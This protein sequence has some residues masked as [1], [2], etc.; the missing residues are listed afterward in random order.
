MLKRGSLRAEKVEYPDGVGCC[1][2]KIL[3]DEEDCGM[4][5]D[6]AEEDLDDMIKILQ[7]LKQAEAELYIDEEGE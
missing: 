7:D 4:C 3:G 2:W 5:F 1:V 6:F